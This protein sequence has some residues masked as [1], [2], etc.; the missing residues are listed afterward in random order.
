MLFDSKGYEKSKSFDHNYLKKIKPKKIMVAGNIKHNDKL[1]KFKKM[2]DIIDISGG[3]ETN[4]YKDR[5]KIDLFLNN[6]NKL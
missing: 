5:K 6:V 1:D 2:T 3:L 4:R